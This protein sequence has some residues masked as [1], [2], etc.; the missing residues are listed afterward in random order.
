MR[1][2]SMHLEVLVED[3]S[4]TI[5]V[6]ALL[7]KILGPKA[8]PHT[9]KIHAY[10]GIGHLPRNLRGQADPQKRILLDR[11]PKVLHGY[12]RSLQNLDAAVLVV[13]DLDDRDCFQ[14][15]QELVNVLNQCHPRPNALIR[16][17]IEEVE[18]WFLGDPI[19]LK[20]VYPRAKDSVINT[21]IQDSICGTWEKMADAIYQG[22]SIKLKASG[23]PLVGAVKCDW[24]RK[25]SPLIDINHNRSKSFKVFC[26]GVRRLTGITT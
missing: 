7:K 17:A 22:G 21:Y 20:K 14:F 2:E 26:D 4:G 9:Y 16:I 23:Y 8:Q 6:E 1:G 11:L 15:K 5:V 10:K 25:I 24:A 19:A 18:A 13:V 12:G 3:Q